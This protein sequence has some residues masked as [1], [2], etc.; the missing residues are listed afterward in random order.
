MA[1]KTLFSIG[2]PAGIRRRQGGECSTTLPNSTSSS[3][4]VGR[5]RFS[6][7][8]QYEL[9]SRMQSSVPELTD[10]AKEPKHVLDLYGPDVQRPGSYAANC[11][12]ARRMAGKGVQFV[13]AIPHGLGSTH[14]LAQPDSPAM[15]D[16][17][18]ASAG[19]LQTLETA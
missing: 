2:E 6:R 18:R 3:M 7:E 14:R 10:L 16:T 1:A 19:L 9:A 4:R 12:L 13:S 5:P 8:S 17:D 11:L 15:Q